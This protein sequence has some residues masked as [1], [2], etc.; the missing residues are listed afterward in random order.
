VVV[1]AF[2]AVQSLDVA[3]PVEV[4]AAA[5]GYTVTLATPGGEP[6]RTSSGLTLVPDAAVEHVRGPVDTLVVAGGS[7]TRTAVADAGLIRAVARLAARARRVTSVCTGA[8]LLAEAGLLDGRRATTHWSACDTL[9]RLYPAVQVEPDPIYTRDGNVWT[10]AGVTAGMDLALALVEEDL[11]RDVALAIAR[12]LVLFLRRPGSQS[13]FSAQLAAQL[14]ERDGLRHVQRWIAEHPGDD[15]SVA[16]LAE[17]AGMSVRHFARSFHEEIGA[18][19]ARYVEQARLEAA[20][21]LLE[22]SDDG[23]ESVARRC[24]FGTS[25]TMRRTFLRALHLSP[26]EYRRRFQAAS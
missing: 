20:R 16:R 12:R 14:A 18:T 26:A 7:G 19:P 22:E 13:Q 21:R 3:G 15:L 11:G 8:F 6:V 5:R 4:F 24:G 10:S 25:E 1:V 9:A 2:P 23:V 17:R